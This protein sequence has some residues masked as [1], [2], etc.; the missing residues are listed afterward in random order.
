M[1]WVKKDSVWRKKSLEEVCVG[2]QIDVWTWI[3]SSIPTVRKRGWEILAGGKETDQGERARVQ[4]RCVTTA[5][6]ELKANCRALRRQ[7]WPLE[8][9]N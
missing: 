2:R 6:R 9:N 3:I 7:R 8:F 1:P 4:R 5:I